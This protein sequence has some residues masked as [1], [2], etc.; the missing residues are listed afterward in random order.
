MTTYKHKCIKINCSNTYEDNDVDAYYCEPCR[1]E[2]KKIAIEIE[3]K[4]AS[5]PKKKI[6]SALQEYDA[7]PKVR[8]FVKVSL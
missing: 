1:E 5:L 3:R 6:M 8:G 4:I 7:S 2:N